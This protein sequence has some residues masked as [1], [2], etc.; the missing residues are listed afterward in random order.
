MDAVELADDAQ[1]AERLY[2]VEQNARAGL[3]NE[4]ATGKRA[5]SR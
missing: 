1:L 4:D 3:E 5:G 2:E